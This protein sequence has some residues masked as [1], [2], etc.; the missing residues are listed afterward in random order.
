MAIGIGRKCL[1]SYFLL[2]YNRFIS[3]SGIRYKFSGDISFNKTFQ[4]FANFGI[5]A[6]VEFLQIYVL[7]NTYCSFIVPIKPNKGGSQNHTKV[8]QKC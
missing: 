6:G 7:H 5:A 3:T 1:L 8:L 2:K 4:G